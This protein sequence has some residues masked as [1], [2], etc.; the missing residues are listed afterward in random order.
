MIR[1]FGNTRY[2]LVIW[3][4]EISLTADFS[5]HIKYM[6]VGDG[7]KN[8]VEKVIRKLRPALQLRLRYIAQHGKEE[9]PS[10]T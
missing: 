6:F 2:Y 4:K 5:Y 9:A 1:V 7:V 8:E 10:A 3:H